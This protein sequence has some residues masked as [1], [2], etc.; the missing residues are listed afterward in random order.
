MTWH[1]KYINS[2]Q[3]LISLAVQPPDIMVNRRPSDVSGFHYA[4]CDFFVLYLINNQNS[5]QSPCRPLKPALREPSTHSSNT[6]LS[7]LHT[8]LSCFSTYSSQVNSYKTTCLVAMGIRTMS[9]FVSCDGEFQLC[10]PISWSKQ[11]ALLRKRQWCTLMRFCC[12]LLPTYMSATAHRDFSCYL[13]E[14]IV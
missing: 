6:L 2:W 12:L 5:D 4:P 9:G 13:T 10:R 14:K 1:V 7:D 3:S 8:Y 11:P